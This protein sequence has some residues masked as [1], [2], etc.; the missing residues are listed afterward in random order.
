MSK[1]HDKYLKLKKEADKPAIDFNSAEFWKDF[2]D[3]V[4][5]L[6]YSLSTS[7]D[8]K[9]FCII[10]SE[11]IARIKKEAPQICQFLSPRDLKLAPI[12]D[13]WK[14]VDEHRCNAKYDTIMNELAY[15]L[16]KDN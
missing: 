10:T 11:Y 8:D 14:D 9:W 2:I 15:I 5:N 1:L 4:E 3:K 13:I 12:S 16:E 7:S 6:D